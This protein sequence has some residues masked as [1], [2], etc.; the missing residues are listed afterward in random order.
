VRILGADGDL[1][2]LAVPK[3]FGASPPGLSTAEVLHPDIVL[4]D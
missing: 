3:G 1:L 4:L 2:A